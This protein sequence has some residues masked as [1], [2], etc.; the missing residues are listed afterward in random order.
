MTA[1]VLTPGAEMGTAA[2]K[3]LRAARIRGVIMAALGIVAFAAARDSSSTP[4]TF[5]FWVDKQGGQLASLST[6]VGALWVLA[7]IVVG[8]SGIAQ[9]V[10]GADF[11]WRRTLL[12]VIP[13]WIAAIL[14]AL[15]A[16]KTANLTGVIAGS[17]ELAVPISLGAFAGILSERSG[18]L[19]IAI[20]GKFL[21]GACAASIAASVTHSVLIGALAAMIAGMLVGLLLA[22]L[23]ILYKVA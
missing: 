10:R 7:G 3:A 14:G 13:V 12:I 22:W 18:M 23:G 17:L 2:R 21:V 19:N 15:L 8:G 9:L 1:A 11:P 16:G 6:S 4:A 5:A 20:E